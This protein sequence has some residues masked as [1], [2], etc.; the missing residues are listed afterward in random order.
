[1]LVTG[2]DAFSSGFQGGELIGGLGAFSGATAALMTGANAARW[3]AI[4]SVGGAALG[5]LGGVAYYY[6][7]H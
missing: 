7:T 3:V 2:G 1:M 5:F 4:G 6:I